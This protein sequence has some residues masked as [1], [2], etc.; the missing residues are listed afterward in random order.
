MMG[1]G[2]TD[3]LWLMVDLRWRWCRFCFFGGNGLL[4][5]G[6]MG[7]QLIKKKISYFL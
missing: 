6:R 2:W 3:L 7:K 1:V 5:G 4:C